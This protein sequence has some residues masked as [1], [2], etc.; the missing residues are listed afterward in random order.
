MLNIK[1]EDKIPNATIYDLA[2]TT[3]LIVRARTRQLRPIGH[4]LRLLNDEPAKEYALYISSH[5]RQRTLLP[6][7]IQC[8]PR[9]MDSML[10]HGQLSRDPLPL[11]ILVVA[12]SADE[13]DE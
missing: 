10:N 2:E 1:R 8:H 6:K 11:Y 3:P 7:Y 12:C 4:T 13:Y 9:D 5:G